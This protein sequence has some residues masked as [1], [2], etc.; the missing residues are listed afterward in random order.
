MPR[1]ATLVAHLALATT[2]LLAQ[3]AA[4]A[5]PLKPGDD[6]GSAAPRQNILMLLIGE[7]GTPLPTRR[8]QQPQNAAV[9][10]TILAGPT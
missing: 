3:A 9:P 8:A 1:L 10:Q 2:P 4:E 6:G 7:H 5:A